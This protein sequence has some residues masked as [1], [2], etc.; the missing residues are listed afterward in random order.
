MPGG[1]VLRNCH[2]HARRGFEC[3]RSRPR[4]HALLVRR[5]LPHAPLPWFQSHF[6]NRTWFLGIF[7][8]PNLRFIGKLTPAQ[9]SSW[10]KTAEQFGAAS[11]SDR[12]LPGLATERE[13]RRK[14]AAVI[15]VH[16]K[17]FQIE[18]P[19]PWGACWVAL[20][21]WNIPCCSSI[22]R[23]CLSICVS[24]GRMKLPRSSTCCSTI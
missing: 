17:R 13:L 23:S 16:L 4:R 18:R 12:S 7:T 19:R 15:A 9:E 14:E 20:I 8:T 2:P 10:Q 3:R 6:R 1:G 24:A 22:G 5:N 21:A 11:P